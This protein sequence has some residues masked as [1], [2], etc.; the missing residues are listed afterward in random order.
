MLPEVLL[1]LAGIPQMSL[2]I[3]Y[4]I[5]DRLFMI[6][7][8]TSTTNRRTRDRQEMKSEGNRGAIFWPQASILPSEPSVALLSEAD[9]SDFQSSLPPNITVL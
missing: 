1:V 6:D 9:N 7:D 4:K 5:R 2:I 3:D 8:R